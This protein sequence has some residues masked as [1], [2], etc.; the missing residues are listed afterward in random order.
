MSALVGAGS[1][2]PFLSKP[3]SAFCGDQLLSSGPLIEVALVAHQA[4]GTDAAEPVAIFD[5]TTGDAIDLDLRCPKAVIIAQLYEQS[6]TT[7]TSDAKGEKP[8][9]GGADGSRPPSRRRG[10][11]KL[12]V[13]SRE[14]TLLPQH[15]E[16]LA[17]QPGGASVMLRR[18]VDAARQGSGGTPTDEMVRERAYRFLSVVG[19]HRPNFNEAVSALLSGS[20]ERFT[21]ELSLWP[22]DVSTYALR[23]AFGS[24]PKANDGAPKSE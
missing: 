20:R 15:W 22:T 16:W 4:S 9:V 5:D 8:Q 7:P 17:N 1:D 19:K 18:L 3:C 6:I 24:E 10:R 14:I 11:P 23:L 13:I 2:T 12:G 21:C